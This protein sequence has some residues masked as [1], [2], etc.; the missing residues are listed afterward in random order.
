MNDASAY[1]YVYISNET[2]A[3][4]SMIGTRHLWE[5]SDISKS[6][7]GAGYWLR[8]EDWWTRSPSNQYSENFMYRR[9]SYNDMQPMGYSNFAA[10]L[11]ALSI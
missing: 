5:S 6:S 3:K 8:S 9:Y 1:F 4:H 7:D 10:L 2:F 11:L